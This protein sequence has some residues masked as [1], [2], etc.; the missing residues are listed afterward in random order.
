MLLIQY[1]TDGTMSFNWDHLP[2]PLRSETEIRDKIFNELQEKMK[3]NDL[4]TT[5]KLFDLN[6]YAIERI[7]SELKAR[8]SKIEFPEKIKRN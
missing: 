3:I 6:R 1:F 8:K 4:V 7:R 5:K 2:E